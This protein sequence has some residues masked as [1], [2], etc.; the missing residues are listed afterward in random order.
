M[1]QDSEE[2][3]LPASP[4]KLR[5]ARRK[6][7]VS[8]SRDLISGFT[9]CAACSF[10]LVTWP[11][12]LE[13]I[14]QLVQVITSLDGSFDKIRYR[15]L[16]HVANIIF[17]VTVPLVGIVVVIA[18]LFG[19]IATGGP[20]FSFE[21]IKPKFDHVNPV[22]GFERIASLRNV[23]EFIKGL[24][25]VIILAGVF[26]AILL[27]FLQPLFDTPGCGE[28]C[29]EPMV[30]GILARVGI[31]AALAFIIIGLIDV[32]IQRWLYLRD[33]RMTK[34]EFKRERKDME[35]D[36]HIRQQLRRDRREIVEEAVKRGVENASIV[37]AGTD[38]L[39]ALRYVGDETPVPI[40]VEKSR[41]A[42]ARLLS[43]K[44]R[45]LGIPIVEDDGACETLFRLTRM[46]AS[47]GP[48]TFAT[49]IPHLIRLGLG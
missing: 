36:P 12:I 32:P 35:G 29:V 9:F 42:S 6:G 28:T 48:Q 16:N 45:T 20:V 37:F 34:T 15:A 30:T 33:M 40:V 8:H 44:A 46:G 14:S 31:A 38:C 47:I 11:T 22:K 24:T 4:K 25:K 2:K 43:A 19:V 3:Q 18:I 41:G 23:I 39:V 10:L 13:H 7:Q 5:E 17:L 1:T 26:V 21:P 49:V 27:M